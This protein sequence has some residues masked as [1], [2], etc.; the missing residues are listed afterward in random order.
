MGRKTIG[1][2]VNT[3]A[4][5]FTSVGNMVFS[6][7]TI[8]TEAIGYDGAGG[9]QLKA[10]GLYMIYANFTGTTTSATSD[11]AVG[12]YEGTNAV[13]GAYASG[14]GTALGDDVNLA[15]SAVVSV[16]PNSS[17]TYATLYFKCTEAGTISLANIIVEKVA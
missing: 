5:T 8:S 3:T 2:F 6:S 12:M 1:R 11:V 13:S 17:G 9:V 10:P 7:T 15:F 4:Q 16:R 14:T